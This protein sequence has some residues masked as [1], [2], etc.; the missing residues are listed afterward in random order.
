[1]GNVEKGVN[2]EERQLPIITNEGRS[3]KL[4]KVSK[5]YPL[6]KGRR[7]GHTMTIMLRHD[8]EVQDQLSIGVAP[9]RCC[10]TLKCMNKGLKIE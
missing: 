10:S 7:R 6:G 5:W 3:D 8:A 2:Q 1:M 9:Q 4:Y